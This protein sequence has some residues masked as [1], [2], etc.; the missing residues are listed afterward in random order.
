MGKSRDI[1]PFLFPLS[2]PP[3]TGMGRGR[4]RERWGAVGN[5]RCDPLVESSTNPSPLSLHRFS[6]GDEVG[7]VVIIESRKRGRDRTQKEG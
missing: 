1:E 3:C 5:R 7:L 4:R 6:N 2:A